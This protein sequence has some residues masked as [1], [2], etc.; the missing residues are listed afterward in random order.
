MSCVACHV[1]L[2]LSSESVRIPPGAPR[3]RFR[4]L[5][6]TRQSRSRTTVA[7]PGI[8]ALRAHMHSGAGD[9]HV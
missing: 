2:R 8:S 5:K 4:A 7:S 1:I 6:P 9:S 3:S